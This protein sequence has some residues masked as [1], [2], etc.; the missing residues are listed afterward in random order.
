MDLVRAFLAA[1]ASGVVATLK[2]IDDRAAAELM[3]A[4]HREYRRH[5]DAAAALALAIRA[6]RQAET[7]IGDWAAFQYIG[8]DP[9]AMAG[10]QHRQSKEG[11]DP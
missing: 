1:G 9:A 6:N 7:G 2:P 10:F 5:G 3:V 8:A 11:I 4:F